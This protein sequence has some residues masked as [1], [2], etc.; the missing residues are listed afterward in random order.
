MKSLLPQSLFPALPALVCLEQLLNAQDT[1]LPGSADYMPTPDRPVG[2]RGDGSG[3]YPGANPPKEW[4]RWPKGFGQL[5]C[6]AQKPPGNSTE[7]MALPNGVIPNWL[8]TGP[9]QGDINA[10]WMKDEATLNP[11]GGDSTWRFFSSHSQCVSLNTAA[12]IQNGGWDDKRDGAAAAFYAFTRFYAKD[13]MKVRLTFEIKNKTGAAKVY[14]NGRLTESTQPGERKYYP[15]QLQ[16]GW[17]TLL[18]KVADCARFAPALLPDG[19]LPMET[20]NIAWTLKIPEYHVGNNGTSTP[21]VVGNRLYMNTEPMGLMCVN[22]TDGRILWLHWNNFYDT[23]AEPAYPKLSDDKKILDDALKAA[24]EAASA[25]ASPTGLPVAPATAMSHAME[26]AK[27]TFDKIN[28]EVGKAG[29]DRVW[30]RHDGGMSAPTP[31]CDGKFVYSLYAPGLA[32]C[33][34]LE[35]SRKWSVAVN[36]GGAPEH[37]NTA[38]PVLIGGKLIVMMGGGLIALDAATGQTLWTAK[39]AEGHG[40]LLRV[41]I[42]AEDVVYM[43][44]PCC[45]AFSPADGKVLWN[46]DNKRYYGF[47]NNWTTPAVVDNTIYFEDFHDYH[48]DCG[49]FTVKF[50]SSTGKLGAAVSKRLDSPEKLGVPNASPLYDN[51]L[52]YMLTRQGRL[53]VFDVVQNAFVYMKMLD[54]YS[55]QGWI[56]QP[57]VTSSPALSSQYIYLVD[58]HFNTIVIKPGRSF[59]QVSSNSICNVGDYIVSSP[60]LAG[61]NLYLRGNEYLYCIGEK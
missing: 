55:T 56:A 39:G 19:E 4:S 54:M 9:F 10:A 28:S 43:P 50:S 36:A 53:V 45:A 58:D 11:D 3:R 16:S 61:G 18:V 57:G 26:K 14:A 37:G 20:H 40:S 51:G 41:K 15:F 13:P 34:D 24:G 48:A 25:G 35:G 47:D 6:S 32:V 8:V 60:V 21:I 46:N 17:N 7:G 52:M 42:G 44:W 12:E 5:R 2:W 23:T 22:R 38:S 31:I 49:I 27:A 1:A 33:Y 30:G 29:K 59:E